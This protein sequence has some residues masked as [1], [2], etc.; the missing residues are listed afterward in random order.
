MLK[1]IIIIITIYN[2]ISI[3][4]NTIL[5]LY[6]IRGNEAEREFYIFFEKWKNKVDFGL[7]TYWM[8]SRYIDWNHAVFRDV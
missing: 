2:Y 4:F 5:L 1:I 3:I 6:G 8:N 7:E